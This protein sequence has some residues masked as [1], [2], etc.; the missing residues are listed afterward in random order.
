[1][2]ELSPNAEE[3]MDPMTMMG[4]LHLHVPNLKEAEEFYA[5]I[6]GFQKVMLYHDSALFISDQGYHHHLGLNIW[7]GSAPLNEPRQIG[8][9][10][11]TLHVPQSY[12]LHLLKRLKD[13]HL[14]LIEENGSPYIIDPLQQ[15]LIFDF[16][17]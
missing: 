3:T 9:K 8:L 5:N 16:E 14:S 17:Q 10:A 4:H 13:A 1:M 7:Q 6:L 12:Y 11:Y 2:S 15:K